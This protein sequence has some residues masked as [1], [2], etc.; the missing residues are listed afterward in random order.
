M[1]PPYTQPDPT[2]VPAA[3]EHRLG[4]SQQGIYDIALDPSFATNH[5][6]YVFYTLGSPNRD[7]LSRFTA[8]A[9]LTGRSPA[10]S[11]S[12][13][14]TRGRGRRAPRRRDRLRQRRQALLHD[15][16]PVR[17]R[18]RAVLTNSAARS[19]RINTDGTVPTDNPFYD[20]TGPNVDSI[21]ALRA[22]QPVPRPTTT[23]RPGRFF[24]GD[25]GGN[26]YSTATEEVN[27][28]ARGRE[29][30]LAE[31]RGDLRRRRTRAASTPTRTTAATPR[32][33]AASS[34]TA[35]SSRARTTAATSSPT[36][37]RTGS[38]A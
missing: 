21:W 31:L 34:T 13:T 35:R 15:R 24:I 11:S 5:F 22:A 17:R 10:A 36:T 18:R 4:G 2:P 30:R 29:L 28:G 12:S 27:L 19:M 7:R 6:F 16:R 37:R 1:P 8:N 33:P 25:V 14:R 20:G 26:D 32:S 23:R 38:S 3:H 9:S